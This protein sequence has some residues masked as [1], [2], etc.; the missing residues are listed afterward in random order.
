V[1]D[2]EEKIFT[3][4]P[5]QKSV[6]LAEKYG[7]SPWIIERYLRILPEE[8]VLELLETNEKPLKKSIRCN[9]YLID[10]NKLRERLEE[11]GV[12]LNKISFTKHGYYVES[13]EDKIGYLHEYMLGYYYIQGPASMIPVEVLN[14]KPNEDVLDAA[15]APGGKSTQILQYTKDQ[16]RLLAIDK[17]RN[18][19]RSLRSHLSRMG[20][21]NYIIIRMNILELPLVYQFDKILLDAPCSGE[22]IIRKDPSRKKSRTIED[23]RYLSS[24]QIDMVS[25]LS[26]LIKEDG[27]MVYSTCTIGVEEN[28]YVLSKALERNPCLEPVETNAPGSKGLTSYSEVEFDPRLKRCK[29]ILPHKLDTEG[30]FICKLRRKC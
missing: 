24:L 29:R 22:G 9:D 13:G 1:G 26:R 15:A 25:H 7:Y 21:K 3:I 14:P 17:N 27:V 4:R 11:K 23:L 8:E 2:I 12:S 20:F 18:R 30:F 19:I 6:R 16:A 5:T 28:E 10:C